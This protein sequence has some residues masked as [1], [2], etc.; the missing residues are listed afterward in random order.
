MSVDHAPRAVR[1]WIRCA[2]EYVF[3][4]FGLLLFGLSC[5]IWSLLA[6]VLY[7]VLPADLGRRVGQHAIM[8]G[9]RTYLAVMEAMGL[10][11]CDLKALDSVREAGPMVIA[12][13]H[14]SLL[15]IVVVSSRLP[16]I[17]CITKAALWN[18]IFL[19]GSVRLAGYIRNDA[20]VN[21][22]K[23]A[24]SSLHDGQQLLVFPEGTRTQ[25][26]AIGDLKGGFL[27]MARRANVP[28]Q[29]VFLEYNSNFLRKGWPLFRKPPV[30]V[31]VSA[32]LGR[33][34]MVPTDL[35][36]CLG[37]L[38]SEY[39]TSLCAAQSPQDP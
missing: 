16:R 26:G 34:F 15:D 32:R 1:S 35:Q 17:V 18:N 25:H 21:L 5:L 4:W 9:F 8:R 31:V 22:V 19:G 30:P 24:V 33:R 23:Q 37:A 29:T 28:V 27:L 7:R 3:F 12:P 36:D 6:A 10:F 13:N 38:A 2:G 14:P 11:R 39:R 20:P